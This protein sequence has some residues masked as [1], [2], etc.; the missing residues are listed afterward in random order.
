MMY[1]NMKELSASHEDSTIIKNPTVFTKLDMQT[2]NN[3]DF[4]AAQDGS[5]KKKK[6]DYESKDKNQATLDAK[7]KALEEEGEGKDNEYVRDLDTVEA[8]EKMLDDP[9]DSVSDVDGINGEKNK[10]MRFG[11]DQKHVRYQKFKRSLYKPTIPPMM[12][13]ACNTVEAM[14]L[15]KLLVEAVQ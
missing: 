7:K 1:F 13:L 8:L 6:N 2:M 12:E 3:Y 14:R 4:D 15:R 9:D 5:F 11:G 10:K